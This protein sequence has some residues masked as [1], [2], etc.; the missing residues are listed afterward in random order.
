M[1]ASVGGGKKRNG[2]LGRWE[3]SKS[4]HT[5]ESLQHGREVEKPAQ[6]REGDARTNDVGGGGEEI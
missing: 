5:V 2:E 3:W 4:V 1:T 6:V